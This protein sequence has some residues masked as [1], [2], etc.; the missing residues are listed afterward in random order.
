MKLKPSLSVPQS[1]FQHPSLVLRVFPRMTTSPRYP[2]HEHPLI[3][4]ELSGNCTVHCNH[5]GDRINGSTRCC[6]ECEVFFH[7]TCTEWPLQVQHPSHPQH[8]LALVT[9]NYLTSNYCC[10]ECCFSA[11][12]AAIVSTLPPAD[13]QVGKSETIEHFA[14]E[15]PLEY[16]SV[17]P[18]NNI[19]CRACKQ[20]ISSSV[21]GCR[22][23]MFLLHESCAQ[24]PQEILQHPFHK[25]HRLTLLANSEKQF[26]C[27]A[28]GRSHEYAY[29]CNECRFDLDVLCAVSTLPL[30]D[31][32]NGD[33]V[34]IDHFSHPH[35][36]KSCNIKEESNRMTCKA[37][38]MHLSGEVYSC[39]DCIFFL[40][41][42]C[43]E[44]HTELVH[45]LHP[46][47]FLVLQAKSH[48]NAGR[49]HCSCCS[50]ASSG[51]V[52][53]CEMCNFNLDIEC[54]LE[55]LSALE[56]GVA[57]ELQHFAHDH[58]LSLR[59]FKGDSEPN[60]N[61][62]KQ[63]VHGLCYY[64]LTCKSF[65]LHKS[66]CHMS[67]ELKHPFHP[68]HPLT[69]LSR[70]QEKRYFYC[71]ACNRKSTG[72]TYH[73]AECN[74][75]LDIKCASTNPSRRHQ[76]HE[77]DLTY[78][79]RATGLHCFA[80]GI[81]CNTDLYRCVPCNFNLHHDCLPLPPTQLH[82]TH[83]H[84]LTLCNKYVNESYDE[85]YCDACEELRNLDHGVYVCEECTFAAH[86]PCIISKV[87]P[88]D[89]S[90]SLIMHYIGD[91]S[92]KAFLSYTG[93][94]S[95]DSKRKMGK[96]KEILRPVLS[97]QIFGI[98]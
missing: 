17:T 40:H 6:L 62:C 12:A 20:G 82:S 54:A 95:K 34:M 81:S 93:E 37:C 39:L 83:H 84:P 19:R 55:T 67:L 79:E 1:P 78:F 90:T 96:V 42:S 91:K 77:H 30:Q 98:L 73:C 44:L 71:N 97:N 80:C 5:C 76:L 14:H 21:Y 10:H 22:E 69:I 45:S 38:E 49:F 9:G 8:Q 16:F 48:Q 31:Q 72:F 74:F 89:K 70:P 15:H 23:C 29:H 56:A 28:C 47:H 52:Y 26:K 18:P 41:R 66:Y 85:Q 86:I 53:S 57:E 64:C 58:L 35:Q 51:F 7:K 13:K 46:D 3:D 61:A 25:K 2:F 27:N 24:L 60:C 92:I 88:D 59:Y 63:P 87:C 43:A 33:S 68:Q 65:V 94:E 4:R 75:F 50:E 11:S 32:Q 36:L